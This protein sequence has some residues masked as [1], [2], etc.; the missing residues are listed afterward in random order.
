MYWLKPLK[1]MMTFKLAQSVLNEEIAQTVW[2]CLTA[3]S[4]H[5]SKKHFCWAL[6][7]CSPECRS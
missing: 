3:N 2:D 4:E 6:P 1:L 7:L 5:T